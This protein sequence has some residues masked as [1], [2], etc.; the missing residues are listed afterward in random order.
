MAKGKED[1][2]AKFLKI[3]ANVPEG[4]RE[5]IIAVVDGKTYTWNTSFIEIKNNTGLGKKILKELE[6]TK[7]I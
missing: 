1:K 7:I 5:D 3:Y 6:V 2:K 4:L